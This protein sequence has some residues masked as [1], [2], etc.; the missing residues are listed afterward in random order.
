MPYIDIIEPSGN[1]LRYPLPE[2]GSIILIGSAEDCSIS[3]PQ[4]PD[5]YPQHCTIS[6]QAEGYVLTPEPDATVLVDN[7]PV[8]SVLLQQHVVY[9][10]GAAVLMYSDATLDIPA[11]EMLLTE[12]ELEEPYPET[13]DAPKKKKTRKIVRRVKGFAAKAPATYTEED[14]TGLIIARRL[15]VIAILALAFLA[16]LTLRYWMITG[17]YLISELL[18]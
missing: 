12:E 3:L 16:G 15:Y 5:I 13:E 11:E 9:T 17:D 1:D 14:S 6:L 10:I 4:I 8:E 2:D 18:K 7:T